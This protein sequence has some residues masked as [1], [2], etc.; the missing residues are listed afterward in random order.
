MLTSLVFLMANFL[1]SPWLGYWSLLLLLATVLWRWGGHAALQSFFPVLLVLA[2]IIPPPLNWDQVLTLWLRSVAVS[3]SSKLLDWFQVIHVLEGNTLML[4]GKSLL[5]E[6]ACSGINSV[7]LCGSL[8]LFYLLWQRRPLVWSLLAL[9][10]TFAFVV[11][12]NIIRIT[13]GALV[14][15]HWHINWLS[16]RRH[17]AVGL[18]LLL[19]YAGL[20]LSLDQLLLFFLKPMQERQ[21]KFIGPDSQKVSVATSKLPAFGLLDLA[22][23]NYGCLIALVGLG[24][25]I[26]RLILA[27]SHGEIQ[28][29]PLVPETSVSRNLQLSLPATLGSWQQTK[30]APDVHLVETLAVHSLVWH[31][32]RN[33]VTAEVAV[34][35]PLDGFHNVRVCYVSSGWLVNSEQKLLLSDNAG[36][37]V[38]RLMLEKTTGEFAVVF[39]GVINEN[40]EW[41]QPES[42]GEGR[43]SEFLPNFKPIS[44][45]IQV[46]LADENPLPPDQVDATRNL[47]IQASHWLYPQM[48]KQFYPFHRP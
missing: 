43:F 17:E 19:V 20:I 48:V 3:T 36:L 37:S 27:G 5:V 33:G 45:R 28:V 11:Q 41:L 14:Y 12:G 38:F 22:I 46:F 8:C 34:D 31:Y 44:Y 39:H 35:Y 30:A 7:V 13:S 9:P 32:V 29:K 40:G 16:G 15:Y 2:S 10:V 1:W 23:N 47:F 21:P 42:R 25:L 18:V 26:T 6:E 24:G 4:P